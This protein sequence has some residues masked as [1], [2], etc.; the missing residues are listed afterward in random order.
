MGRTELHCHLTLE[1]HRIDRSNRTSSCEL[2]TLNRVGANTATTNNRNKVARLNVSCVHGR[3]PT[4]HHA[5]SE[6]ACFVERPIFFDLHAARLVDH[7]VLREG[8]EQAHQCEVFPVERVMS[9]GAIG[10]LH[11]S[12]KLG[13]ANITKV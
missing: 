12:C 2:R 9:G 4:G 5:T 6:Q 10:D 8:A 1:F 13:A 3:S 7:R 11:A